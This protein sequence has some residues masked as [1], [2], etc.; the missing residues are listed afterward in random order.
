MKTRMLSLTQTHFIRP[1]VK[2]RAKKD[3]FVEPAEAPGE[4]KRR[5][6]D[7]NDKTPEGIP[8]PTKHP[9]K[10]KIMEIFKIKEIDYKKFNEE[11]KWAIRP[12]KKK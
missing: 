12:N 4:G 6:P 1:M 7:V 9:I 8:P 3:E 10:Q 5:E 2:I 11:N